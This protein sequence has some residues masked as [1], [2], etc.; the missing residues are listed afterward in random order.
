M[1]RLS[2]L[3]FQVMVII[4]T[5][6]P[7]LNAADIFLSA[8]L[9]AALINANNTEIK[10]N[11]ATIK[12]GDDSENYGVMGIRFGAWMESIPRLGASVDFTLNGVFMD[13]N[14]VPFDMIW[15]LSALA[16]YRM[17][18]KKVKLTLTEG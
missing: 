6:S 17:P 4:L 7:S 12:K 15:S 18:L 13:N 9:G 2:T 14:L 3:F 10:L 11:Q 5:V 16:M 8:H 1:N